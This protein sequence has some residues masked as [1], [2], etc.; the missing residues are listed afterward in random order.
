MSISGATSLPDGARVLIGAWRAFR[1]LHGD[2]RA[3][4]FGGVPAGGEVTTVVHAGHFSGTIPLIEDTL[5]VGLDPTDPEGPVAAVD[6]DATVCARFMTG[7]D[8]ITNGPWDQPDPTVRAEVG[9][10]GE[11]LRGSPH[12]HVFGSLTKHPS[13]YLEVSVRTPVPTSTILE[14]IGG[15]QSQVPAIEPLAGFCAF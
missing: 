12:V 8:E 15:V 3:A 14:K 4:N 13:R 1:Q 5:T 7:R 9:S 2:V 10:F 11:H 6:P